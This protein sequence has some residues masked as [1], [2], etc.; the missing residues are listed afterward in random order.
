M[1]RGA[2]STTHSV[3]PV[4]VH[5]NGDRAVSES[6]GTIFA[7]FKHRGT[8]YDLVSYGRFVSR[9][10]RDGDAWKMCSLDVIYDRDAIQPVTPGPSAGIELDPGARE[11]YRC[12]HWVLAQ[13]GYAIDGRLP[14]T[15]DSGSG[16]ALMRACAGWLGA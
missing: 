8:A 16:E 7:R 14:G 4:E 5:V 6:V 1:A 11:S 15:D 10:E 12:L 3:Q 13:N 2:T 9:L